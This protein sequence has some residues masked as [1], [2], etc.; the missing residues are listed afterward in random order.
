MR[1]IATFLGYSEV[2]RKGYIRN[3]DA[4]GSVIV[5]NATLYWHDPN[6]PLPRSVLRAMSPL[7]VSIRPSMVTRMKS[8]RKISSKSLSSQ[9]SSLHDEEE[10]VY[11]KPIL[12]NVDVRVR[13][14]ELCAIVGPVGSGK[15]TLCSAI[16][17]ECI[18]GENSSINLNGAVAYVSQTAWILNRSVRENIL[19]GLPYIE[20]RYNRVIDSCCLRHDLTILEDGDLTEIGE[21]GINLSGGEMIYPPYF[22]LKNDLIANCKSV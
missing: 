4:D 17:N 12:H 14:G 8:V 22:V 10:M 9:N 5:D 1:R 20:S 6:I 15:S 2:N 18:L 16:L 19:F 3:I 11:P 21:R 7:D 13:T